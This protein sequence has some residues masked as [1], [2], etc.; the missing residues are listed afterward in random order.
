MTSRATRTWTS[1]ELLPG[2]D[3]LKIEPIIMTSRAH[4]NMDFGGIVTWCKII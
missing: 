2:V 4:E 1:V 3:N